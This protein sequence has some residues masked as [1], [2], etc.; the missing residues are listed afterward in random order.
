MTGRGR[1][2]RFPS[3]GLTAEAPDL[4]PVLGPIVFVLT[5]GGVQRTIDLSDLACPR[6]V[7]PLAAALAGIGGDGGTVRRWSP[8]FSGWCGICARS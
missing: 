4:V 1:R 8:G 6:L 7:R 5:F 2:V 3:A